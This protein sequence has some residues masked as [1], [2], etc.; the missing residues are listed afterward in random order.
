[1]ALHIE[2]REK[3]H[4][5]MLSTPTSVT[6]V[7]VVGPFRSGTSL[8]YALLN[9]HPKIAIMYE[10]DVWDF[11]QILSGWRFRRDWRTRLEFYS[12]SFSRHRL[13][14]GDNLRG[15]EN[16][17]TPEDLYRAFA[18]NKDA[19]L[20]GEKSP[21][22]CN[23]LC[24][25]AKNHPDCSFILI[26]RDPV[27]IYRSVEEAS[28]RSR[29][30]RRP[31]MLNR[32]IYY[33][34]QM[35]H[36]AARLVRAGNRVHHLTYADLVDRTE[37]SCRRICQFLNI[38]FD[39]KMLNLED[40]DL[41]AV[42]QSPPHE[43]LRR[44]KIERRKFLSNG[45]AP[46]A[47]QKLQRF[48]NRWNRLTYE[49]LGHP[50]SPES[51]PEPS[52]PEFLYHRAAGS[53]LC[54]MDAA[55]RALFEFLPLPWL[56]TYR[57][58]KAWFLAGYAVSQS[59]RR[60]LGDEFLA[61]KATVLLGIVI[62]AIVAVAD[63]VTGVGVSLM[64]FYVIPSAVLALVIGQRWG[65]FAAVTSALTWSLVQNVESPRVNFSHPAIWLWDLLMHF[66]ILQLIVVLLGRI[67]VEVTSQKTFND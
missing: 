22:Y 25:L 60:P 56:R 1:M 40:A 45:A 27:E 51:G 10:C 46:R 3:R 62:L 58:A 65:T 52:P 21:F 57:Q 33:Q 39:E 28:Y 63:Y 41:S 26:W 48:H 5:Q 4:S 20:F 54:F 7:F 34:E 31:G 38:E 67:R 12:R 8:L 35:I 18:E 61:N 9:Q 64:P 17:R 43:Y 36:E 11:P 32:L 47:V 24:Q 14:F 59:N 29:F 42:H 6:P 66:L 44:G 49:L 15:L 53:F 2:Y 16:V 23:R 37:D 13:I 55:K 50:K 30:F 19:L